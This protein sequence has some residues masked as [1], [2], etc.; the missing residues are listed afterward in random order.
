VRRGKPQEPP[1]FDQVWRRAAGRL[2]EAGLSFGHGASNAQDEAAW[3]LIHALGWPLMDSFAA[4]DALQERAVPPDAVARFN[5][6]I[7]QRIASRKPA[8]YLLGEAWL[9]GV[10]FIVDERVIVPRSFIAELLATGLDPWLHRS[11]AR[12]ADICT[13]SGCLAIL[14]AMRWPDARVLGADLAAD[15]LGVAGANVA[16]HGVADR[17][18]LLQSDLLDALPLPA[19]PDQG[20]DLMLCNPPYVNAQSMQALPQEYRHEPELALAGGEDG[21]DLVRRLLR[22]AGAHLAPR[23]VLVVE[24]GNEREHFEAAFPGLP[25]AWL[26]TSAGDDAVFLVEAADLRSAA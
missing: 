18:R 8:A 15:A 1:R 2:R 26:S 23:G 20:Y 9:Q 7:D 11:P 5:A 4:F 13:G 16:L 17:V 24:I 6:L 21:M 22:T 25:V 14:A 12:I 19:T 3:M 10:R